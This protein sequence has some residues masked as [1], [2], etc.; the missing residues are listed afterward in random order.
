V[1]ERLYIDWSRVVDPPKRTTRPR[2]VSQA[3]AWPIRFSKSGACV[4]RTCAKSEEV[5]HASETKNQAR[6]SD[7]RAEPAGGVIPRLL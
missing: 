1:S 6:R 4:H 7:E 2:L 3:M 5:G